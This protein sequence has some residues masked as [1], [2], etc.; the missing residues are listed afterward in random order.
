M[1]EHK[2]NTGKSNQVKLESS[3][4]RVI[5]TSG[6]GCAGAKAGVE[7]NT[8]FVGN[9]SD[10]KIEISDKSGRVF[11]TVK[12][13]ISGN[14][15][16][17]QITVP[18]NA[19]DELFAE[20]KLSK[21]SL[22]KKSNGLNLLPLIEIK[23]LKWDR[24]EVHR[25]DIVKISADV[26]NVYDGA[27]AEVQIWEFDNDLAHD[28]ISSIPV[29][30]KKKKIETS[31]E[32]Q[33]VDDTDDIPTQEE[34]EKGYHWPEYFFRVMVGGKYE[35]SGLLKFKDWVEF[36]FE[37]PDGSILKDMKVKI[38]YPDGFSEEETTDE[39][40]VIRLPGVPPGKFKID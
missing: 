38:Y 8:H 17:T 3:I 11:E 39:N 16:Y 18:E 4:D 33:Y 15:F 9:N 13:K 31:W 26:T 5:W 36:I 32:F 24:D 34:S 1:S 12:S 37:K 19:E 35:D 10:I 6:T 20:V 40:G 14:F 23:N 30:V 21:H 2:G 27:E 7:V 28:F 29:T 25:G 22:T